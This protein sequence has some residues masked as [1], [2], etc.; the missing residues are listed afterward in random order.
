MNF[1][2]IP[3]NILREYAEHQLKFELELAKIKSAN[4]PKILK[5]LNTLINFI[6]GYTFSLT[7]CI[8]IATVI[9][10]LGVHINDWKYVSSWPDWYDCIVSFIAIYLVAKVHVEQENF[11]QQVD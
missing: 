4:Q 11:K 7:F 5:Y 3:D 2:K 1:K 6:V 9:C 8:I 10:N